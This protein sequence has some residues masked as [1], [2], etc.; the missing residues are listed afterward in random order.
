MSGSSNRLNGIASTPPRSYSYDANGSQTADGTNSFSYDARGRLT[1]ATTPVG[2]VSYQ[3]NAL[4]QRT[5]KTVPPGGG[6]GSDLVFIYDLS[7]HLIVEADAATGKAVKEYLYL[8][9]TPLAVMQ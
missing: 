7:G 8:N 4:G 6:G 3:I 1:Q 9:D 2:T 5:R